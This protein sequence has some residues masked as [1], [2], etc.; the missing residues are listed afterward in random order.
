MLQVAASVAVLASVVLVFLLVVL[1]QT[2]HVVLHPGLHTILEM[3]TTHQSNTPEPR[4]HTLKRTVPT[5][6]KWASNPVLTQDPNQTRPFETA[7]K[8]AQ[9]TTP[10]PSQQHIQGLKDTS[11][12]AQQHRIDQFSVFRQEAPHCD[13]RQSCDVTSNPQ[14]ALK[15]KTCRQTSEQHRANGHAFQSRQRKSHVEFGNKRRWCDRDFSQDEKKR[16]R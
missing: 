10:R 16:T 11:L 7:A 9:T 1:V 8:R 2:V 12:S 4:I 6:N 14:E 15:S 5:Q 3:N 13:E